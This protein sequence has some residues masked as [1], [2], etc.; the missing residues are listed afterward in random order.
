[1]ADYI[2]LA[3]PLQ[4]S[5]PGTA[6]IAGL[7][8]A[9]TAAL[10][11]ID[12]PWLGMFVY[13]QADGKTYRVTELKEVAVGVFTKKAVKTYE[14]VPDN[15]ALAAAAARPATISLPVPFDLDNEN[16]T[17]VV[18]FSTDGQFSDDPVNYSR[19]TMVDS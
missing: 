7:T 5:T 3:K 9:N 8:V 4:L 2:S 15:A 6:P 11:A 17:L 10:E 18:D 1:M 12:S 14:P 16:V 13:V 19:V